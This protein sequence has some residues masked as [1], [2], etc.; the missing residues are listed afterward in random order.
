MR[1]DTGEL[2]LVKWKHM[3]VALFKL[4]KHCFYFVK[5]VMRSN[6]KTLVSIVV[7]MGTKQI[8]GGWL[9]DACPHVPILGRL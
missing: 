9:D 8:K 6:T 5:T 3:R 1:L 2:S 4:Q 7:P